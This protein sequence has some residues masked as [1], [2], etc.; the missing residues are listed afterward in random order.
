MTA[1]DMT[2]EQIRLTGLEALISKLGP[3]DTVRF[4]QQFETG[5]GDYSIDRHRWLDKMDVQTVVKQIRRQRTRKSS[6]RRR[7]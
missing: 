7:P 2:L 4:L 3:V 5:H 6:A 1:P